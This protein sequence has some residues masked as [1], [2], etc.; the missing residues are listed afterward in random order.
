MTYYWKWDNATHRTEFQRRS[1]TVGIEGFEVTLL[2]PQEFYEYFGF[3]V[4]MYSYK[5]LDRNSLIVA[6][7]REDDFKFLGLLQ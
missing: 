3:K 2:K 7:I 6:E 4:G 1:I 5:I